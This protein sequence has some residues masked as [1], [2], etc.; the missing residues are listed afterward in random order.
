MNNGRAIPGPAFVFPRNGSAS[1]FY[2]VQFLASLF[3]TCFTSESAAQ[4]VFPLEAKRIVT[5]FHSYNVYLSGCLIFEPVSYLHHS[6]FTF[7]D[8]L[9]D[10][11]G[12]TPKIILLNPEPVLLFFRDR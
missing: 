5:N 6:T 4:T 9:S 1:R 10:Y 12:L 7:L 11:K 3:Q 8:P 2:V